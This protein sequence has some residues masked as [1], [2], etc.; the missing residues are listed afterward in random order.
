M[1]N[2]YLLLTVL[3]ASLSAGAQQVTEEQALQKAQAFMKGKQL[4]SSTNVRSLSRARSKASQTE[5]MYVFNVEDKGGFVIVSGDERTEPILGYSTSGEIDYDNMPDNLRSWLQGYEAQIRAI[6]ENPQLARRKTG[7]EKAAI[8]P[9]IQTHWEQQY[10]YN[11]QCPHDRENNGYCVTGCVAT[12]LA[13]IMYYYRWPETTTAIPAYET[14]TEH[15][16]L[17]ELPATSFKWDNMK[18]YYRYDEPQGS[19]EGYAVAELMRYCGQAM[20]MDYTR[21]SSGTSVDLAALSQYFGYSKNSKSISRNYYSTSEWEEVIYDE[22]SL[23][24]PVLYSGNGPSGSH[25]FLCDGYDGDGRF[26]INFGWGEEYDCYCVLSVI[27]TDRGSFET[28]SGYPLNHVATIGLIPDKTG[29]VATPHVRSYDTE[30]SHYFE[31]LSYT[32][33][34]AD[35]DFQ[36][37]ELKGTLIVQYHELPSSSPKIEVGWGLFQNG[38]M[39]SCLGSEWKTLDTALTQEL[40]FSKTVSFGAGLAEGTYQICMVY[41]LNQNDEWMISDN[42]S[43]FHIVATVNSS[44]LTIRNYAPYEN[45]YAIYQVLTSLDPEAKMTVDVYLT[46][47]GEGYS[48]K[49]YLW[50]NKEGEWKLISNTGGYVDPGATGVITFLFAPEDGG[51]YEMKITSDSEGMNVKYYDNISIPH[52]VIV[53][54]FKYALNPK[55]MT[56]RVLRNGFSSV[57]ELVIPSSVTYEDEQYTVTEIG[58]WAFYYY[59]NVVSLTIPNTVTSI[60]EY[61]FR[62]LISLP[63]VEIPEGV[64]YIGKNAYIYYYG[65]L[66]T[67][68]LNECKARI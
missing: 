42:S 8:E 9:M 15:F 19:S 30:F 34:G 37:V 4:K 46:N 55:D 57:S 16:S 18:T 35:T 11:T 68:A 27:M 33:G 65:S 10:P 40:N 13:Q 43:G 24:R 59:L 28:S 53:D 12:A 32:R 67:P 49:A 29:E 25:E 48:P 36:N 2:F 60:G 17:E 31:T 3:F 58:D 45:D 50:I 39:L 7:S 5:S 44:N 41:R 1:R 26:H 51:V 21:F 6:S 66:R 38:V 54:G 61:A 62:Q 63:S 56:A 52:V 20:R 14:T 23:K 22:L 64:E 47:T